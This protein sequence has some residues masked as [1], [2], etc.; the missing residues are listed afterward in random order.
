MMR[1][2]IAFRF[3]ARPE[4]DDVLI[5]QLV[6]EAADSRPSFSQALYDRIRQSVSEERS[7]TGDGLQAEVRPATRGKTAGRIRWRSRGWW[8]AGAAV[9]AGLV[10]AVCASWP[11]FAVRH[12]GSPGPAGRVAAVT[13]TDTADDPDPWIELIEVAGDEVALMVQATSPEQW[14]ATADHLQL[15]LEGA[16]DRFGMESGEVAID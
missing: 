2:L 9:T 10:A 14:V 12:P 8:A 4:G 15:M 16:A 13:P 7:A 1:D 11:G 3:K 5:Q 6:Q